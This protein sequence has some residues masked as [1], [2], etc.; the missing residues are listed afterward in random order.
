MFD[1]WA[2]LQSGLLL[3]N[4][5]NPGH[6]TECVNFRHGAI[7]GQHCMTTASPKETPTL[8]P[9]NE[10]FDWREIGLL[11]RNRSL[12]FVAGVCLPA[13]CS[14]EKV[15]NYTNKYFH[16]A[17]LEAV[18]AVCRNN[19]PI[20]FEWIDYFAMYVLKFHFLCITFL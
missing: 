2:K 6:F 8:T 13:S 16:R 18:S 10:I 15:V 19:D 17:D 7:Q 11:A 4:L 20:P 9:K 3:G 12:N 5:V 14:P 1:F